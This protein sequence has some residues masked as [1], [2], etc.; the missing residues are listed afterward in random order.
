MGSRQSL[1]LDISNK[2]P[3]DV[4]FVRVTITSAFQQV[5]YAYFSIFVIEDT[6]ECLYTKPL[7]FQNVIKEPLS[8]EIRPNPADEEVVIVFDSKESGVA[9]IDL[10]NP[11]GVTIVSML[12]NMHTNENPQVLLKTAGFP[13][14]SYLIRITLGGRTEMKKLILN[15]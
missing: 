1:T 10:I 7:D 13:G 15:H 11:L 14:G 3:G 8:F 5:V 9:S 6:P 12:Q 4:V 2:Q